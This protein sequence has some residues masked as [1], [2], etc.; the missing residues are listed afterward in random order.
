MRTWKHLIWDWNG[1]VWDDAWLCLETSNGMLKRRGLPAVSREDY[2]EQFG[3]PVE[4]YYRWAGFD[5]GN[6]PFP[7]LAIEFIREYGRRR[8]E[9][10]LHRGARDLLGRLKQ[11]GVPQTVLSAYQHDT[12]LEAVEHYG[13]TEFFTEIVGLDDVYAISKVEN[14]LRY[15]ST[16]ECAPEE[17]LFLGDTVHDFEVA[18]AMGVRCALIA[19]GH[20]SRA[21]LEACGVP[22]V[23]SLEELAQSSLLSVL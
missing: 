5:L 18:E 22:V 19:H 17:V 20:N 3:F 2:L 21:R 23:S 15:V 16:L 11:S 14:G 4:D 12:L 13:L 10:E 1:T 7:E 6:E 8:F 9:C